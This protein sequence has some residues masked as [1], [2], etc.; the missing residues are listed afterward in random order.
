MEVLAE[1]DIADPVEA[2]FYAPV[3]P[4][5]AGQLVGMCLVGGQGSDGVDGLGAPL[6][7]LAG[8]GCEGPGAAH[9]LDRLG[10]VGEPETGLD[11]GDL[12]GAFLDAAVTAAGLGVPDG[13]VRPRLALEGLAQGRL[14]ALDANEQVR[15]PLVQVLQMC[16]LRV[17][18]VRS[19]QCPLEVGDLV[20]QGGEQRDLV[21]LDVHGHLGE[22]HPGRVVRAANRCTGFVPRKVARIALPSTASTRRTGRPGVARARAAA[23]IRSRYAR[24]HTHTT[25]SSAG[26]SMRT[27]RRQMVTVPGALPVNPTLRRVAASRSADHSPIAA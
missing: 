4:E 27:S 19:D 9:D 12:R 15:A 20:E 6:G 14:V 5:P 2:H 17:D 13:D 26:A 16:D 18:S 24:I 3:A 7:A 22:D 23:L 1:G 8:A 10:G 21:R 11:G 25:S